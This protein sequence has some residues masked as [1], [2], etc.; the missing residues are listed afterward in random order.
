MRAMGIMG[1]MG[2]EDRLRSPYLPSFASFPLGP[3]PMADNKTSKPALDSGRQNSRSRAGLGNSRRGIHGGSTSLGP[4]GAGICGAC[5]TTRI[6]GKT[7][8][9]LWRRLGH[10]QIRRTER[11][12]RGRASIMTRL[13]NW[14]RADG[15]RRPFARSS[16][17]KRR[18]GKANS[19]ISFRLPA[20]RREA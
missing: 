12:M 5:E 14:N 13:P 11:Q 2:L 1:A 19:M 8:P 18:C 7:F 3:I 4:G 20:L 16:S 10:W 9:G 17:I 15:I 6:A